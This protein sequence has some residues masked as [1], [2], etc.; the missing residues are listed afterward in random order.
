MYIGPREQRRRAWRIIGRA[1]WKELIIPLFIVVGAVM[2]VVLG[3]YA[4]SIHPLAL[5]TPAAV[6]LLG[7]IG[8]LIWEWAK[9]KA[10]IEITHEK[11]EESTR[12]NSQ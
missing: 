10:H 4:W 11:L 7:L 9:D 8:S 3:V 2:I 5:I 1:V 6:V 12:E